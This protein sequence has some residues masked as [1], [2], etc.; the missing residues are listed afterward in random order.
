MWIKNVDEKNQISSLHNQIFLSKKIA[1]TFK[2]RKKVIHIEKY[3]KMG[4]NQVINGVIHVIH[5]K[6]LGVWWFTYSFMGT[7]VL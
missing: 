6:R 7:S 1:Q 2:N 3:G 5:I 4:K